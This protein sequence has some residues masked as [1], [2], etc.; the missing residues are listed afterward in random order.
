ME[1]IDFDKAYANYFGENREQKQISCLTDQ[2]KPTSTRD[3]LTADGNV[4]NL[5]KLGELLR[6]LLNTAWGSGWGNISPETAKVDDT[7]EIV[8][9]QINYDINLREVT[10]G[11]SQ[12]PTLTDIV[13]EV[14]NDG[15]KT[16]DAYKIYRQSFDCIVE[17]NFI[18]RTSKESR[19]LMDRFED[20]IITHAGYLKEQGLSEIFFLKEVPSK[21]SINFKEGLPIKVAYYFVRLEKIRT[22]RVS[23]IKEIEARL[24][25][26]ITS[27]EQPSDDIHKSITYKL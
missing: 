7:D 4:D 13:D 17:F 23:Q 21:Y 8:L 24:Y 26:K 18:A 25:K 1:N 20:I 19:D 22:I 5:D 9:P 3:R 11:R 16:G 27:T 2:A 12:K 15:K 10:E 14:G 6:M